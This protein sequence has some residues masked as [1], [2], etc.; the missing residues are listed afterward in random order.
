MNF[1]E[2]KSLNYADL[3]DEILAF[4]KENDIFQKSIEVREGS[5]SFT[6]Y[7]GPPSANGMPGIHHVMA[8]TIKDIFCR[9]KTLQGFQVNRKGGWDTHGLPIELQVEKELGITKD[10]IGTKISVE[11][12]NLKCREAVM[13]FTD[14]WQNM[15]DKMGYWVDMDDPYITYKNEYIESVW[16]LLKEFYK[17]GLLYKGYTI[18]PFSPAAGT[19]LSSHELNMPGCYKDV[20]DTSIVA[21]FKVA[22]KNYFLNKNTLLRA[23]FVQFNNVEAT[24]EIF[25]IRAHNTN[26][27]RTLR[28]DHEIENIVIGK[29]SVRIE[30]FD[31]KTLEG[32]F[33]TAIQISDFS[34]LYAGPI[35]GDSTTERIFYLCNK[36]EYRDKKYLI[37]LTISI[38]QG[39]EN[40]LISAINFS[41]Y[42]EKNLSIVTQITES[43]DN[44]EPLGIKDNEILKEYQIKNEFIFNQ[45]ESDKLEKSDVF[46]L[47][48]TT[49]PWT[50]PSN[51]ALTI[52]ENITYSLVSTFNPYTFKHTYVILASD[53]ITKHFNE[54]AKDILIKDYSPGDK[55]IPY[56]IIS[57]FIGGKLV[58]MKYEQLI[59]IAQNE[60]QYK[61]D[62]RLFKVVADNFVTTSDGTGIVH[63][64]PHF[65][66]DDFRVCQKN[67][68][69]SITVKDSQ[70]N[71]APL[72]DRN[73]K[74]VREVGTWLN[75]KVAEFGVKTHKTFGVNDF[76]VK[77]YLSEDEK[78]DNYK[79]TDEIISIVLKQQN[80][81]FKVEKYEHSYPHCW[82]TDKPVLYY[83][84]DSWFIRTTAMK[85]RLVELNKTINWAPESTGTGRFGNWLENLVD[86][87]LSRSRYWGTPLPIWRPAVEFKLDDGTNLLNK[88]VGSIEDL[89]DV[90]FRYLSNDNYLKLIEKAEEIIAS[91]PQGGH[92]LENQFLINLE[93]WQSSKF[94]LNNLRDFCF[95]WAGNEF[96][97][98][99]LEFTES[100]D[101]FLQNENFDLHRPYID[102]I[103]YVERVDNPNLKGITNNRDIRQIT[104]PYITN[105]SNPESINR[106]YLFFTR[107]TDL[108]DVWFDSGAMPYAQLHYPFENKELI[109][110]GM[111]YPAD[112]ISEGVDQTRGW[113]FTLHAIAGMLFDKV[114]FKNV[115]STGLVLD[116]LGNKMS[117][118]KGNAV[119]PFETM[120]KYGPDATRWYMITNAE[121]WD[122]LKFNIDGIGEVQRKF[123]GTLFNTYNFFALYANLDGYKVEQFERLPKEKLTELDRWI[124]SK[125]FTLA[126][127]VATEFDNYNPTKAGRLVQDFVCDDLSNWYVRLN[128]RRFW[129]GEMTDDKRA[130]Y[131]TLQHCLCAVAQMMSPIAPFFGDWL[132]KSVTEHVRDESIAK[133][134]P[135]KHES[136]HFTNWHSYEPFWVDVELEQ[137]MALAQ[138]VCSLVHSLRK[139]NKIKVRQPLSKVLIPILNENTRKQIEHV[140]YIIESE[141]NIK[142]V[143]FITDESGILKK[144]VKPNFKALGPK[145]GKDMKAVADGINTMT[146]EDLKTLEGNKTFL[147]PNSSFQ[148]SLEDVEIQTEDVPGWLVASEGGVT[149]ALDIS[150]SEE[151]R[152]EGIARDFVNR[153]QNQRKEN[154]YEV[155]DK[156]RIQLQNNNE[157]L[158]TA[159]DAFRDYICE[160]VQALSL[161]IMQNRPA[162]ATEIEMDEFM[163]VVDLDV[164]K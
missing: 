103:F 41:T 147:I 65:G 67:N 52:G 119:D 33:K 70:Y 140:A 144:K 116:K 28:L 10:D 142:T 107:E 122:N 42:D 43:D 60:L 155:T 153:I 154:G 37:K 124:V 1:K 57:E 157:E 39:K 48:W 80:A 11:E 44:K 110:N 104:D 20:K 5:P 141:V 22:G 62:N 98:F 84:L 32:I 152:K 56:E 101:V 143:D 102:N 87:N 75:R 18:Q 162:E 73:G 35:I 115:V 51:S 129:K 137:S 99:F 78:Q 59:P 150:I 89:K 138:K 93:N 139:N 55:L 17:K 121:P 106:K 81:A 136:V 71:D 134:T 96:V 114:A 3:A 4:W 47:A 45:I 97:E 8:R 133:N 76:Y 112:F 135:F 19:G 131:Q 64:A 161:T 128:R 127:D 23:D 15:T 69:P 91:N 92:K 16:Y 90:R 125:V 38:P 40:H 50:L 113:F 2:Y 25:Q 46:F 36:C 53:L 13:R 72:V 151:L 108:I 86:W 77:N 27:D 160:E 63:T 14:L 156:I 26:I 58:G 66:A 30:Q 31:S 12:Y 85:D 123:F 159:V 132:Y 34:Y 146:A 6:F 95:Y 111:T 54:K 9:Y 163:L 109:D 88:V 29:E 74:F 68:I 164:V 7:E 149:V 120:A 105:L 158:A 61:P 100:S 126:K 82:R 21:Q 130:A 79:S 24:T 148:I 49:T 118:S 94:S 145:Y 117:K 83:P